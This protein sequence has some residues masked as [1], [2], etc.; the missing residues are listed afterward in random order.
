M[1]CTNAS[2]VLTRLREQYPIPALSAAVCRS[3]QLVWQEAQGLADV[4]LGVA[5]QPRHLFRIGSVSK[6]LTAAVAA[7]LAQHGQVD[8]DA[9]VAH[10]LPDLPQ[11][12]RT[13]TLRQLFCHQGGVRHYLPKDFD[14]TAPGGFIDLRTYR[15][16]ADALALFIDDPLVAAPGTA[17]HYSTFG[18]TLISTVLEAASGRSFL[19]LV[20][21]EVLLP[22]G[23][24]ETAPDEPLAPLPGRVR[25]YDP[26]AFYA[27]MLK[28]PV[29][30]TPVVNAIPSNPA[31][32]WAG[33]GF[34]ASARDI[35]RFGAAHLPDG[36]LSTATRAM[37]FAPITFAS[38]A[39]PPLGLGWRIDSHPDLGLRYHH[40]GNMQGCRAQ[41][42]IYPD[43]Q[44]A[45]ALLGNLGMTPGDILQ[46]TDRIAASFA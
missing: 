16:S 46:H 34:V 3:G 41:L 25:N 5:A 22:L 33:G 23:L 21:F 6:L 39:M 40:A 19:S 8:L 17:V 9:P 14:P 13:T 7:R 38:E 36:Y 18:Y 15:D 27:Q 30:E 45:V 10:Y 20:E 37:V 31:Y 1:A 26:G 44:L 43:R 32:K 35:A 24:R 42:A 11:Q 4:E 2:T 12:H 29:P 28:L